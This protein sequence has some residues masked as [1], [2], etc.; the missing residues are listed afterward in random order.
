MGFT[1]ARSQSNFSVRQENKLNQS[2]T[3][4]KVDNLNESEIY[5]DP[6]HKFKEEPKEMKDLHK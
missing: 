1:T 2:V 4:L 3:S 5:I 6:I